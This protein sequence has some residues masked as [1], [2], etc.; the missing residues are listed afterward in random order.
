MWTTNGLINLA[1]KP[2]RDLIRSRLLREGLGTRIDREEFDLIGPDGV[3]I[4][5]KV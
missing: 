4:D 5:P 1:M 2:I 3:E